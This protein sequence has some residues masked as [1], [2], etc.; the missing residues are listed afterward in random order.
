MDTLTYLLVDFENL[1]PL[2]ADVELVRGEAYRLW[3]FHGPHQN[4]FSAELVKAWQPLGDQVKWVQSSKPGKNA[5]DFHIAFHL[6]CLHFKMLDGGR[7]ARYVVVSGDTG[8]DA[9]FDHMRSLGCAVGKAP[10]I[11]AALVLAE[12]MSPGQPGKAIPSAASNPA[13]PIAAPPAPAPGKKA[14]TKPAAVLRDALN[15]SD[16]ETVIADLRAHAGNRPADRKALQ[17]HIVSILGNKV[18]PQVAEAAIKVLEGRQI[19]R[20]NGSNVE[21][22]VPN[23]KK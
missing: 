22:K 13:P 1:Q 2:P 3:V 8:F 4:K 14:A 12:T 20:F 6:G 11:P 10:S 7:P 15:G 16:A 5:L 18:T 21:Y 23:A 17:R 9:L 19:V